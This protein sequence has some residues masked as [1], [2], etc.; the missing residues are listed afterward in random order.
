MARPAAKLLLTKEFTNSQGIDVMTACSLYAVLYKDKPITVK[1]RYY[2]G[3][4]LVN[5]YSKTV[6]PN[7]APAEN[8]CTKLNTEFD[9][10]EFSVKKIL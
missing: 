3:M 1:Q 7:L 5:K 9:T 10:L 6:F 8:L 2:G 4:G